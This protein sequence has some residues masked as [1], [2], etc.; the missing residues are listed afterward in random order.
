MVTRSLDRW[1][2]TLGR[3]A[4]AIAVGLLADAALGEPPARVHP[5][6][7]F[8]RGMEWA[9]G[10]WWADRR[11]AGV[12]HAALGVGAAT[13]LGLVADRAI[14]R[15]RALATATG[16]AA[17]A[18]SLVAAG[19]AVAGALERG[20]L[21]GA[22]DRLPAL[23]GR[24]TASLDEKEI[25]RAV[26]E[27][28]SENLSDAVV[29][30]VFWGL[31]AGT[32]GVLAHRAANTLDAMVGHRS[33][34]YARFGWAAARLDDVLAWPAAR[35][36]VGLVALAEPRRVGDIW[37]AVREQAPG[38]PSPN[39]GM[40]EAAF[41]AAL[42]LRLGGTNSY[43]GRVE[44][45]PTL[46]VGPPPEV[47]DIRRALRLARRVWVEL[48]LLLV[49]MALLGSRRRRRNEVSR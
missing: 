48:E 37:H 34:R 49:G 23:V 43:G 39:A 20:D 19:G 12:R 4:G 38:H 47:R 9:E 44:V 1:P 45:R 14:G 35:L 32:P 11:G 15:T 17:A 36:T 24:D 25:A 10:R 5:V 33:E 6:A 21:S 28:L 13:V 29:A 40:A 3:R 2:G 16:L 42:G 26:I 8:G 46:G 27:S 18:R 7:R 41:A 30:S 31:C 22:R